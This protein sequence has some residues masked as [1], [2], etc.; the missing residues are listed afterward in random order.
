[1]GKS[2]VKVRIMVSI[3]VSVS[4]RIAVKLI[5]IDILHPVQRDA[6]NSP[7]KQPKICE[8]QAHEWHHALED[9]TADTYIHKS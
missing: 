5:S 8:W 1:M 3:R 6:T 9:C 4:M 7:Y 2:T